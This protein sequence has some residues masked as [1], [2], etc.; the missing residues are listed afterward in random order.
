MGKYNK[1]VKHISLNWHP[2]VCEHI[3]FYI[4]TLKSKSYW[5]KSFFSVIRIKYEQG[6]LKMTQ[7]DKNIS[8]SKRE[9]IQSL[10][11]YTIF[12][13]FEIIYKFFFNT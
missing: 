8:D 12:L 11:I 4:N 9:N 7:Q 1:Y 10:N 3:Y 2:Y 13:Y 6:L 5:Y